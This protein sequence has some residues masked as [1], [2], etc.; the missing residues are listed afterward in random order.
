MATFPK[1]QPVSDLFHHHFHAAAEILSAKIEKPLRKEVEPEVLKLPEDGGYEFR[2]ALPFRL[3]GI[4]SY[5]SGY[6]QVAG[7]Q[8]PKAGQAF[9]TLTTSVVEG[10]NI[11]DVITADRVVGQISTEHPVFPEG[12]VPSV[13]FLGTRFD[14]LR[15]AGH[16]VDIEPCLDIIGPKPSGDKSYFEDSGVFRRISGQYKNINGVKGLPMWASQQ[17]RWSKAAAFQDKSKP[18]LN[19]ANCSLVSSVEGAPGI[20]FGHVID[21]PNF[22]RIFLAELRVNRKQA[23][24]H[25]SQAGPQQHDTYSFHLTMIRMELG[26]IAH[27][28]GHVIALDSNGTGSGGGGHHP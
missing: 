5:E 17:Y 26:C 22:G 10:L 28:S 27:G 3:E 20:S 9:R 2:P 14:N 25:A 12:Q 1:S 23:Q 16:K 13:T 7:H 6:T 24:N 21:L 8:S 4:I 19:T 18:G 15:I 11:L